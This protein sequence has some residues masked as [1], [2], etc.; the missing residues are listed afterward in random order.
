MKNQGFDAKLQKVQ[1]NYM[2]SSNLERRYVF[3]CEGTPVIR[4]EIP[5]SNDTETDR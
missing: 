3:F 2:N 1:S 5:V 4:K